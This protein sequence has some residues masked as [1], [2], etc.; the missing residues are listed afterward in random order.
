LVRTYI[1]VAVVFAA[2]LGAMLAF[3]PTDEWAQ[4]GAIFGLMVLAMTAL[5]VPAT[6]RFILRHPRGAIAVGIGVVGISLFVL[7]GALSSS[8]VDPETGG[9]AAA[10]LLFVGAFVV[11]LPFMARRVEKDT[12]VWKAA[13]AAARAPGS[14]HP[15]AEVRDILAELIEHRGALL[16]VVGPW[17]LL[18]CILPMAFANVDYWKGLAERDRG[19]AMMILLGLAVLVLAEVAIMFVAMIQW[20]RFTATKQEP[21]LTAFP[22][23]ALW[24]WA[25]RWLIY[26]A[27]FRTFNQI[28]PWLKGQLPAAP[29]WQLDG[30]L[31]LAGLV[32]LVL[33]SP[34]ALVLPAVALDA[35]DKGIAASMQ[36]FRVVGRKFYLGAIL[37]VAPYAVASWALG[38]LSDAYKPP[39][40]VAVNVGASLILLFGTTI[41]G[42]T[43]LTRVYLR[44]T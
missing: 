9:T 38:V 35:A 15:E 2:V 42:M 23:K 40:A 11:A 32:A 31:G 28:E 3:T 5:Q 10:F 25:W 33:V 21:R 27:A 44:R 17:L 29:Q 43:Y 34:F 37:I 19:A 1:W 20:T 39:A 16:R 30:L 7:F 4:M 18:F 6:R 24:G 12:A 14:F 36:G 13:E 41:V 8:S 26:G 22:G